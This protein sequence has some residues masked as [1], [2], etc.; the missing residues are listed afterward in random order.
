VRSRD[1]LFVQET[2]QHNGRGTMFRRASARDSWLEVTYWSSDDEHRLARRKA[3]F[4][5]RH[6]RARAYEW[7]V[8]LLLVAISVFLAA[9]EALAL[10][11]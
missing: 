5:R 3:V 8:A 4:H 9:L 1:A 2:V 10:L 7:G 11:H 6:F